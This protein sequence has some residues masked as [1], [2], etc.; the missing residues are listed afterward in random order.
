MQKVRNAKRGESLDDYLDAHGIR[1]F[2]AS[3]L[4][5]MRRARVTVPQ[6]RRA[7]W[8]RIIPTLFLAEKIRTVLGH[9]LIVGNGYRPEPFNSSV[10]G[11]KNSQHLHFRA[12]DLDLPRGHKS[13]EEQ[14]RF[15]ETACEFYLELGFEYKIGLGL[16]RPWRGTRIH[17]DTGFRKRRWKKAYVD[18]I[19]ESIR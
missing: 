9:G 6:P 17:I 5:R 13:R 15:Y 10:G 7:L 12:L 4:L 3:E 11:A 8:P 18:P 14:E 1:H 19:L 16:Y 2:S